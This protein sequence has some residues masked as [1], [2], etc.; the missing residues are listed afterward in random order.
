MHKV[1]V[2]CAYSA[3][4]T[5]IS[6]GRRTPSAF[7]STT[8][9]NL[10]HE[11]AQAAC[12]LQLRP[13]CA[14]VLVQFDVLPG[15]PIS[16]LPTRA[17]GRRGKLSTESHA[18]LSQMIIVTDWAIHLPPPSSDRRLIALWSLTSVCHDDVLAAEWC[19][20]PLRHAAAAAPTRGFWSST[21]SS[22]QSCVS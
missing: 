15:S 5:S 2:V 17:S 19:F 13:Q 9:H 10:C 14:F 16:S 20:E 3:H 8:P 1:L 7:L 22:L 4:I 21:A 6:C 12:I 11:C 18:C